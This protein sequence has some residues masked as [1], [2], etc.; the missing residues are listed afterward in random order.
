[1]ERELAKL[2]EE[3]RATRLKAEFLRRRRQIY[4][5]RLP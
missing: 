5:F 4:L 3:L 2:K 1:M